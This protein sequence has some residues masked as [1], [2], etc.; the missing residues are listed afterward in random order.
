MK[1]LN[2]A[3]EPSGLIRQVFLISSFCR[4]KRLGISL[5]SPGWDVCLSQGAPPSIKF[6]GT[7]LDAWVGERGTVRVKCLVEECNTLW[8]ASCRALSL[9]LVC[10]PD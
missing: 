6:T 4:I 2:C 1:R 9:N 3:Y 10:E 5:L 8:P 7:H